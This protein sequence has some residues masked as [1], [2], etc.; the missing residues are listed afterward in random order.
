[1]NEKKAFGL[2][3][4]EQIHNLVYE[5]QAG[6]NEAAEKLID[7][8]RVFLGKYLSLLKYGKYELDHYSVRSFIKLFIE[9][10]KER[11]NI[12]SYFAKGSSRNI[13]DESVSKIITIFASSED[14]DIE[15][16]LYTIFLN[17]CTKYKD[18]RPSFHHYVKRNFHY[19]A[20]RHFEKISK[21]PVARG[22]VVNIFTSESNSIE[23]PSSL[24]I[25]DNVIRDESIEIQ[26]EQLLDEVEM[27]YNVLLSNTPVVKQ[28]G[29]SVYDDA[30][31]NTNW[32]NG[33][34]CSDIFKTLTPFERKILIMWYIKGKTDTDIAEEFGVCRGTINKRRA[35][36]KAKLEQAVI[37]SK[38]I[39]F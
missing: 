29:I 13:A 1:M 12:N 14:G 35:N 17:M 20:Y 11:A 22:H 34:T 3:E 25:I 23:E 36:A 4:Y 6:S 33:I 15:N 2:E 30:F 19:Y 24:S 31:L 7:S 18:T 16:E 5:Y 21:D 32:I 26:M 37:K 38:S 27:H 8:F 39:K 10:P 9:D 28:R